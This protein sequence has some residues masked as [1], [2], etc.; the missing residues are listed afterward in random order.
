MLTHITQLVIL[1]AI[2][3]KNGVVIDSIIAPTHQHFNNTRMTT[4][5]HYYR[6]NSL[7]PNY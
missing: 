2:H 3:V 5:R 1:D 6:L 7:K 4:D